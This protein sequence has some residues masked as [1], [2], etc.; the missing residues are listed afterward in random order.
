MNFEVI[1][2]SDG[3]DIL[4]EIRADQNKDNSIKL[5]ITDENMDYL[6]GSEAIQLLANL[7]KNGKIKP[8]DIISSTCHEDEQ[9]K[10]LLANSGSKMQISKPVNKKELVN[11]FKQFKLIWYKIVLNDYNDQFNKLRISVID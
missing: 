9:T 11:A 10:L 6:N 4:S 7:V 8:V 2:G 1:I 5:I 3:I